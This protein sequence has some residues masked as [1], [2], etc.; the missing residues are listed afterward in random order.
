[1]IKIDDVLEGKITMNS[2]GSAYLV[3][4]EIPKDIY[5]NK[6]NTNKALHL[7]KIK[8]KVIAGN[9]RALEGEVI[10]IV[11]RFKTEF[12]GHIQISPRYGFFVP[13]S[14]KMPIDFFIPKSKLL[15]AKD[16]QKVIVRLVEWKDDA[17]NP[18]GEVIKVIGNAG[19]HET[20]IHSI[21]E[22]HYLPYV[23]DENI[24]IEADAI[25]ETISQN[26]IDKRLDL[27][28]IITIGIDPID[29]R[30]A[31]DT[32]GVQLIDGECFVYVNIADVSFYIR[33]DTDIDKEAY[34]RGTSVYLVDRCV[35]MLP[36]RIS[37]DICSLKSGKDK[38]AFSA[39]FKIN[40]DGDVIDKWFGRTIINVNKDYSY[41]E[42]QEVIENGV[43]KESEITDQVI[44]KLNLLAKKLRKEREK[45]GFL[46]L[47]KMDIKFKLDDNNKPI[48]IIFKVSKDSNKLIEEFMLL[49]NKEVAKFIKSK[50]YPSI[51]RVHE[52]PTE[53]KINGLKLFVSQFGYKIKTNNS[54]DIKKSLNNLM[55]ECKGKLEEDLITTLITRTQQKALYTTKD[56]GHYGLGF[57]DYSHFTSPIRRYSDIITH[58]LLGLALGNNGYP[59]K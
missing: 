28:D 8:I 1:M 59:N 51:N 29:S 21:L 43:R 40:T 11:E 36:E 42:A 14:N 7:D 56:L 55:G 5:I 46:D 31:D 26:E 44:L 49:A 52:A 18:N 13:D 27:R 23:F 45:D 24:K 12:V 17:K 6:N 30:D 58:R 15:D 37:N 19:E 16:G 25:Y 38:L 9:G 48:E 54:N 39:I 35:P 2:S 50:G 41:E 53:E 34:N 32:L 20:E 4:N 57:K 22:S 10:E 3:S 33:P 47:D